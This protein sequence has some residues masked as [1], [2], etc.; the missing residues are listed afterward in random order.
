MAGAIARVGDRTSGHGA[1]PPNVLAGPGSPNV[2]IEG[3]PVALQGD[4]TVITCNAPYHSP[5][6]GIVNSGS[7]TITANG[8]PVAR[9]GD[10]L[11]CTCMI[12]GGGNTVGSGAN[13]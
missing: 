8:K 3:K 5:L 12:V 2:F 11:T 13:G 10:T 1:Y 6:T 9:I 7:P 4:G